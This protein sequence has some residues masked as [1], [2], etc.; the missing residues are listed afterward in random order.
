MENNQTNDYN[1]YPTGVL[2]PNSEIEMDPALLAYS[3][4]KRRR[5]DETLDLTTRLLSIN[6]QDKV[7]SHYFLTIS[8]DCFING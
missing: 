1:Q 2:Q 4:Y 8:T 6:W 7:V 3:R 5:F